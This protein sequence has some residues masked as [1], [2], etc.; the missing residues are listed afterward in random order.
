MLILPRNYRIHVLNSTG[1]TIASSG[2]IVKG[3]VWDIGTDGLPNYT[4]KTFYT[5]GSSLTHTSYGN[6]SAIDNTSDEK[7]GAEGLITVITTGSPSGNLTIWLQRS[8]DGGTTWPDNGQGSRIGQINFTAAG[9]KRQPF[10]FP[11]S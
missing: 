7:I 11:H 8:E 5:L 2:I 10:F 6:S 1:V 4:A 3:Y 9:T